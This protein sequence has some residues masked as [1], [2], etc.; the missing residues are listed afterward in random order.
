MIEQIVKIK[1]FPSNNARLYIYNFFFTETYFTQTIFLGVGLI[2]AI[3]IST[4]E[5]I[6][7]YPHS[8]EKNKLLFSHAET[9]IFSYIYI[10]ILC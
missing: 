8:L 1:R 6:S 10:Y 7:K 5:V 4:Q 3:F 2:V 9:R